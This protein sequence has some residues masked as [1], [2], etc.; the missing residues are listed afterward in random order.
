[1]VEAHL[2]HKDASRGDVKQSG[3]V[4]LDSDGDVAEP[5]R[6]VT[7]V[8]E[9]PGHDPDGVREVDDPCV[10]VGAFAGAGS[11]LEHDRDGS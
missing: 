5:D 1:M 10:V 4:P 3:D 6:A 2:I 11:D 7:R 8:E 9:R